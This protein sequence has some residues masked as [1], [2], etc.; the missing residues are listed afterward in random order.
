MDAQ[1][2]GEVAQ[3][4]V[5]TVKPAKCT[6]DRSGSMF[7]GKEVYDENARIR[8]RLQNPPTGKRRAEIFTLRKD[9]LVQ[10]INFAE[11]GDSYVTVTAFG[12]LL[13]K[14]FKFHADCAQRPSK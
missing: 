10:I 11:N 3:I 9:N 2:C 5:E 4:R 6:F 14:M 7:F 8:V 13:L 1:A 12:P